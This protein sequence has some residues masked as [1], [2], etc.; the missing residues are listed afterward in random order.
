[1]NRRLSSVERIVLQSAIELLP[2]QSAETLRTMV[3]EVNHV[4]R[5][6]LR[7]KVHFYRMRWRFFLGEFSVYFPSKLEVARLAEIELIDEYQP[8]EPIIA[9]IWLVNG[10]L[11]SIEFTS[12]PPDSNRVNTTRARLLFDPADPSEPR[13]AAADPSPIRELISE[14]GISSASLTVVPPL[15]AEKRIEWIGLLR[16]R[17]PGD[18]VEI[19][20]QSDGFS[21]ELLCVHGLVG[22]PAAHFDDHTLLVLAEADGYDWCLCAVAG[23]EDGCLVLA[24]YEGQ[25]ERMLGADFRPALREFVELARSC[26]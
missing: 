20:G 22:L 25:I 16:T 24:D 7:K 18:W 15:V 10:R 2:A 19:I 5:Y 3:H 23:E 14:L 9:T 1:M 11:S 26:R 6:A 13:L 17:L 12:P 21:A 8:A 4:R